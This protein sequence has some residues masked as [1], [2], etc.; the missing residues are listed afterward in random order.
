MTSLIKAQYCYGVY[1]VNV[2][3][4]LYASVKLITD[5][6]LEELFLFKLHNDFRVEVQNSS[7]K[8]DCEHVRTNGS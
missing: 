7:S 4:L 2:I 5:F 3:T 8:L 6:I 1:D